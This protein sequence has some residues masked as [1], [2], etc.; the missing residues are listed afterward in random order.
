[1]IDLPRASLIHLL[2]VA[3]IELMAQEGWIQPSDNSANAQP[4]FQMSVPEYM[5]QNY[6]L[7]QHLSCC[8]K[9]A[10]QEEYIE[11]QKYLEN[12]ISS[13]ENYQYG[14]L[15][16][17]RAQFEQI[18]SFLQT[19][20][21]FFATGRQGVWR[22]E[23]PA[24]QYGLESVLDVLIQFEDIRSFSG[25]HTPWCTLRYASGGNSSEIWST[26]LN[27]KLEW[28]ECELAIQQ[29][30]DGLSQNASNLLLIDILK[31]V[32]EV[33]GPVQK[34]GD[35]LLWTQLGEQGFSIGIVDT[36]EVVVFYH[37]GTYDEWDRSEELLRYNL[38]RDWQE[39][40]KEDFREGL[41]EWI[42]M[43]KG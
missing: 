23:F 25:L 26:P 20:Y 36:D 11:I 43:E 27:Q 41:I 8:Q 40:Q 32:E 4:L 10:G 21:P 15:T 2:D 13:E 1:M 31:T 14:L 24:G 12:N 39:E 30:I 3:L 35:T 33:N 34:M 18:F 6:H 38:N 22:Y 42:E 7:Q 16:P 29:A 9:H 19:L 5:E 28:K 17:Y 37:R